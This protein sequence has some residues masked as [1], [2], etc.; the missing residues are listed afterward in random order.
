MYLKKQEFNQEP[1]YAKFRLS[2][3]LTRPLL[4]SKP[5]ILVHELQPDDNFVIF[6]SDGLWDHLTNDEAVN[7][8]SRHPHKVCLEIT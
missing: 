8:V 1:L 7:L 3:P 2:E 4:T 5:T 6:A